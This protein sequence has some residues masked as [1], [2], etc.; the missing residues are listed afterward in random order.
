[1]Q[2]HS[3]MRRPERQDVGLSDADLDFVIGLA[4]AERERPGPPQE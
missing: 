4:D 1:M 2:A 3:G